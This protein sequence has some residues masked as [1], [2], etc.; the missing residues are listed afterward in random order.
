MVRINSNLNL[1]PFLER[2]RWRNGKN[3]FF[4]ENAEDGGSDEEDFPE[5]TDFF[6]G[7]KKEDEAR[8]KLR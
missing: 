8:K 1:A 7:D 2:N 4:Q 5:E 6:A 3:P